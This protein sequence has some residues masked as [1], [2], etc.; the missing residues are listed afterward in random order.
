VL[1]SGACKSRKPLVTD[2]RKNTDSLTFGALPAGKD[3]L[4]RK[5]WEYFS[6]R[7]ATDYT[8]PEQ[9][10]S[11]TISLRMR[12]DSIIWFSIS[13]ALGIQVAKG[14]ITNDSVKILDLY[15]KKY[16]RYKVSKLSETF[17]ADIGLREL[18]NI[19][20]GNPIFD[21]MVY[22]RELN[23][24]SWY[25]EKTPLYNMV[26]AK[27]LSL[28]DSTYIHQKG[29][30]RQINATYEGSKSAGSFWVAEKM[31]ILALGDAKTVRLVIEFTTASDAFI[32]SYPF[33]VP[34]GYDMEE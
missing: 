10:L 20:I 7:M 8:D 1:I 22:R 34:E 13:A 28:P 21:T 14:I 4:L 11:G 25:A 16:S 17:G 15:N 32:P 24:K 27:D 6:T 2:T 9:E 12:R 18:Q 29:S 30:K 3:S 33:V 5:N 26:F 19:I 31:L 23:S